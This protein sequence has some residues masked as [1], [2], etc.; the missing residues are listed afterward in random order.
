MSAPDCPER[1]PGGGISLLLMLLTLTFVGAVTYLYV[2]S[3]VALIA[4]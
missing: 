2:K 4:A 1:R 3:G